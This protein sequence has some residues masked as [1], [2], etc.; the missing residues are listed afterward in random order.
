MDCDN[1]SYPDPDSHASLLEQGWKPRFVVDHARLSDAIE[2]YQEMGF[3]VTTLPV[4]ACDDACSACFA[5]GTQH[6]IY[7][8]RAARGVAP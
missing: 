7:V 6:M 5:E 1:D 8:R 2:T 3:E 4:R